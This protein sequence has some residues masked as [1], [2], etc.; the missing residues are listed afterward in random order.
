MKRRLKKEEEVFIQNIKDNP[1]NYEPVRY[2][3]SVF[4]NHFTPFI[5]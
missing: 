4:F 1:L 3:H 2:K 5:N